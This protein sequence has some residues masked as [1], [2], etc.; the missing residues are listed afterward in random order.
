[1][2]QI[3][4]ILLLLILLLVCFDR[5]LYVDYTVYKIK[6]LSM[7]LDTTGEQIIQT[8]SVSTII[9]LTQGVTNPS[10]TTSIT[11]T[12]SGP[13]ICLNKNNENDCNTTNNCVWTYGQMPTTQM[14][15]TQMPTTQMQM[16]TTQMQ[17]PTTQMPTTQMQMP[18]TQMQMPTT[19]MPTTSSG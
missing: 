9:S 15:T 16:P 13:G 14:P 18:T 7:D 10:T 4:S 5:E 2:R 1:M 3:I 6:N 17:M 19:Q 11:G 12:C 8:Q